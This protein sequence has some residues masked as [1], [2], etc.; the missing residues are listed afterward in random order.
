[1]KFSLLFYIAVSLVTLKLGENQ[2]SMSTLWNNLKM[3][4]VCW[5]F[6]EENSIP[7]SC[8]PHFHTWLMSRIRIDVV[9]FSCIH[10]A[11]E[12]EEL[13]DLGI[14][15]MQ[16]KLFREGFKESRTG[17]L[18][19]PSVQQQFISSDSERGKSND[20]P[21][22]IRTQASYNCNYYNSF[23]W[24]TFLRVL[25]VIENSVVEIRTEYH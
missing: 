19:D 3:E 4:I 22:G 24:Q 15:S 14:P 10:K 23:T 7:K 25:L 20:E 5:K 9:D 18:I 13:V 11:V 16:S 8:Q 12:E 17:E 6:R 1:M 21:S 2:S